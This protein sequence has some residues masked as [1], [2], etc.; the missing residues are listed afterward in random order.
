MRLLLIELTTK[1]IQKEASERCIGERVGQQ[2]LEAL[3]EAPDDKIEEIAS[4][5]SEV[6]QLSTVDLY[7]GNKL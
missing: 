4:K 2:V 6:L 1:L 5:L 7:G 3:L